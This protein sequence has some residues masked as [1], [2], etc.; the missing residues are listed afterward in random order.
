[1]RKIV[2]SNVILSLESDYKTQLLQNLTGL[3]KLDL[4]NCDFGFDFVLFDELSKALGSLTSLE[5]LRFEICTGLDF[6]QRIF[7]DNVI[8]RTKSLKYL[9][10]LN[11]Q[12]STSAYTI[13]SA[14]G[15]NRT[16]TSLSIV[17]MDFENINLWELLGTN[18]TLQ[19]LILG[20]GSVSFLPKKFKNGEF[21]NTSL[22]EVIFIGTS[23]TYKAFEALRLELFRW[24]AVISLKILQS[25]SFKRRSI[26]EDMMSDFIRN[27]IQSLSFDFS[28]LSNAD[29]SAIG[30]ALVDS[31]SLQ[32]LS[33][34]KVIPKHGDWNGFFS[35]L[36]HNS[37]LE[38]LNVSGNEI[39]EDSVEILARMVSTQSCLTGL[40]ACNCKIGHTSFGKL[41]EALENNNVL[42]MFNL[43]R[44]KVD[45]S[46]VRPLLSRNSSLYRLR[47]DHIWFEDVKMKFLSNRHFCELDFP[48]WDERNDTYGKR[49]SI[50][51]KKSLLFFANRSKYSS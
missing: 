18:D 28:T 9:Q 51:S 2:V 46:A 31:E 16:I 3:Q 40:Q 48:G 49:S 38:D 41:M 50:I 25:P 44:N 22:S 7:A 10:L 42:L 45:V 20:N 11:N 15:Q 34:V 37:S 21:K 4:E 30:R 39:G 27:R 36:E 24:S 47:I 8:S 5:F 14:L 17:G 43:K 26:D 29:L 35:C 1:M 23:F 6:E 12:R 33:L 19:Q 13:I 32:T